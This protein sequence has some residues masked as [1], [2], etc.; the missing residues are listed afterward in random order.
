MEVEGFGP[1]MNLKIRSQLSV[2]MF[3]QFFVWGVWFVTMGTYLFK[4]GF[5]GP[6]IGKA[7]STN[8]LGAIIAPFFVG[9]IADRFFSAQKMMGVLHIL[10]GAVL[11]YASTV[12]QPGPLFW[13]LLVYAALY[14]P[15]LA[16]VNAV[17][18][19]QMKDPGSEFPGI[20]V[21]GTIGWIAAGTLVGLVLKKSNPDI[22]STSLP[23]VLGAVVSVALGLYSFF[24][25]STPP[26]SAGKA[27]TVRDVLGLDALALMK[28]RSFAVLVVS[29]L[30]ISIPLAFYYN[31]TNA[32]LN[33]TKVVA[34]PAFAQTFGQWSELGFMIAMPFFFRRLGVK[35]LMLIGML[36][37]TARYALFAIG[38]GGAAPLVYLGI[39]A[40]GVCYD[41]FFV[42]GQIYVDRKAPKALQA[43][44]QGFIAMA[45]YGV[46][47]WI[48]SLVSGA[49]VQ[50]FT[51]ADGTHRWGQMWYV[52]SAMALGITILFAL[53]FKD[54]FKAD[55]A[56]SPASKEQRAAAAV[57]G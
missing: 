27:V 6:D 50:A 31:F 33:E 20:R 46:G 9:M 23:M 44:A 3:L 57:H 14:M 42:T 26:K 34:N 49:V 2:M 29:S 12:T 43:G 10:G 5:A 37:W 41:F 38:A 39:L 18:F 8:C 47:M 48:G 13:V 25:P 45:T 17:S 54:D 36:A 55:D 35:K 53:V 24:L 56:H 19:H 7:Y 4:I 1:H 16:L 52:P 11:W 21:W 28:D 15:T 51:N 22:E 40:H 32:Y 30:L